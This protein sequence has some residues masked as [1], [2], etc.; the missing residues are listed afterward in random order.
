MARK[1]DDYGSFQD[2]VFQEMQDL[3]HLESQPK[4]QLRK[5]LLEYAVACGLSEDEMWSLLKPGMTGEQC[6]A[7]LNEAGKK[8]RKGK[9]L[10]TP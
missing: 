7:V 9:T 8:K 3:E 1:R 6:I 5:A 10:A 2:Q 4:E